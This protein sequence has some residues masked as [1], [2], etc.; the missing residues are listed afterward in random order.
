MVFV[1][2]LITH[3]KDSHIN[4]VIFIMFIKKKGIRKSWTRLITE[5]CLITV[6]SPTLSAILKST[7]RSPFVLPDIY[8][9]IYTVLVFRLCPMKYK[10]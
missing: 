7:V 10:K 9:H 4:T 5:E 6:Q 2:E 3:G 1:E 8:I